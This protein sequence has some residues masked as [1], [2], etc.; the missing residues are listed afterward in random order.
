M[1]KSNSLP[2]WPFIHQRNSKRAIW[3]IIPFFVGNNT[4]SALIQ[5][6]YIQLED[7]TP[8]HE[9]HRTTQVIRL[10]LRARRTWSILQLDRD[11]SHLSKFN[12]AEEIL[13]IGM[14]LVGTHLSLQA[15]QV[16]HSFD[17]N[18]T[19]LVF[20]CCKNFRYGRLAGSQASEM[21]FL[22]MCWNSLELSGIRM[23]SHLC[24]ELEILKYFYSIPGGKFSL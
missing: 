6:L 9:I 20:I 18:R 21:N 14:D 24:N 10:V 4:T 17:W 12:R 23:R 5:Y 16:F 8:I 13:I 3:K 11:W 15:L 22:L 7:L 19:C 1:H 2:K